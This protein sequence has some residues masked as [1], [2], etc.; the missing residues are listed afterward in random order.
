MTPAA[1][2][3]P[4]VSE[5]DDDIIPLGDAAELYAREGTPCATCT[6]SYMTLRKGAGTTLGFRAEGGLTLRVCNKG[7]EPLVAE[8]GT[9]TLWCPDYVPFADRV[10]L[11]GD[12][13]DALQRECTRGFLGDLAQGVR[14]L[15][16]DAR[17]L[18]WYDR[19][20]REGWLPPHRIEEEGLGSGSTLRGPW[21]QFQIVGATPAYQ[22]GHTPA[23]AKAVLQA[24]D[25]RSYL[26]LLH[27]DDAEVRGHEQSHTWWVN[28]VSSGAARPLA[29]AI[30]ARRGHRLLVLRGG[31]EALASHTLRYLPAE[32]ID[33]ERQRLADEALET[34]RAA[35]R[36][37]NPVVARILAR[38]GLRAWPSHEGLHE[39][40]AALAK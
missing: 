12:D 8:G 4:A 2:T 32:A 6:C 37:K 18:R 23:L 36:R 24:R 13:L 31:A 3:P 40:L 26:L 16:R 34:A 20:L 7:R 17:D 28:Q 35:L 14:P 5:D 10:P 30:P 15:P 39:L 22:D 27:P 11:S 38:Q 9:D 19:G 33:P 25:R 29:T 1:Y 21:E